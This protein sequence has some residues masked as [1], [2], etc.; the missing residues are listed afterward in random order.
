LEKIQVKATPTIALKLVL[1]RLRSLSSR[2]LF[3]LIRKVLAEV[4]INPLEDS[5]RLQQVFK[6]NGIF[7]KTIKV[8]RRVWKISKDCKTF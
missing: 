1:A 8:F 3:V 5:R 7:L 4:C 6:N 2:L